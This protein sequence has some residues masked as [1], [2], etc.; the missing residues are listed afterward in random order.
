MHN[1]TFSDKRYSWM[2]LAQNIT[3][4]H[5]NSNMPA[6]AVKKIGELKMHFRS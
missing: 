1:W 4:P 3:V 2:M 5:S 6:C